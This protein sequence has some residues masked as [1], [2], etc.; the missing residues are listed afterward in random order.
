MSTPPYDTRGMRFFAFLSVG[1]ATFLVLAL[2]LAMAN[3]VVHWSEASLSDWLLI[4]PLLL[5]IPFQFVKRLVAHP[6]IHKRIPQSL[7]ERWNNAL[8]SQTQ[9]RPA[10]FLVNVALFVL[11][12]FALSRYSP[13]FIA[14]LVLAWL[15][16]IIDLIIHLLARHSP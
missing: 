10:S 9:S 13:L 14:F 8:G 1:M 4:G 12:L 5:V 15:S 3:T 7:R 11:C 6:Q 2:V 16:I